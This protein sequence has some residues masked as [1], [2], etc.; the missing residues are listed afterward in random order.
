[1]SIRSVAVFCG[2]KSGTH[3]IFEIHSRHLGELLASHGL[4]LIYGGGNKGLMAAVANAALEKNGKVIGIIP[5][6]LA[7][8]EHQ[9]NGLT[10]LHIVENMHARKKMLYEKCDAAII[11]PGG[12]GTLDEL[13]EMLTWNQLRIHH[14]EI[15]F[16]N[17]AGFYDHLLAHIKRMDDENFLYSHPLEHLIHLNEPKDFL[18]YI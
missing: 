10:E 16:L 17:S 2:S 12:Y 11:L 14:K 4:T 6:V 8:W 15:F 7:A 18:Q 3:P 9:H 1:M 5:T 13:F